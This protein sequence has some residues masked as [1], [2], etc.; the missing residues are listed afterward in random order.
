[1]TPTQKVG[2]SQASTPWAPIY[3]TTATFTATGA[4][5]ATEW[6]LAI[7]NG[8]NIAGTATAT[9]STSLT[10]TGFS[11]GTQAMWTVEALASGTIPVNTPTTSAVLQVTNSPANTTTVLTGVDNGWGS[12][13][14]TWLSLANQAVPTPSGTTLYVAFP[15]AWDHKQFSVV[16]LASGDTL[17]T[18]YQLSINSGG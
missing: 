4:V 18:T 9:S 14:K 8:A 5:A 6:I 13:T 16:N 12:G 2:H 11:A 7:A 15:T 10:G 3:Q 1:M 17:L